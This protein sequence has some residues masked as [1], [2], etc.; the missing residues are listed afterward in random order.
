MGSLETWSV[1]VLLML[2]AY[3]VVGHLGLDIGTAVA[4]TLH[5]VERLLA[6]PL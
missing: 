4:Q 5:G 1:A 2:G 3:V 6:R